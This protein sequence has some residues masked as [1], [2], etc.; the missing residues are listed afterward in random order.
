MSRRHLALTGLT[1]AAVAVAGAS[2]HPVVAQTPPPTIVSTYPCVSAAVGHDLTGTGWTPGGKV[3]IRGRYVIGKETG[4]AFDEM[5]TADEEGRIRFTYGVPDGEALTVGT[6]VT[7]QDLARTAA[8]APVEQ[9]SARTEYQATYYGVFYRPWNKR[10]A[11]GRPGHVGTIEASG[12]IG[13]AAR[14]TGVVYAHYYR[15]GDERWRS[16]R[17]GRLRGDCG[18]LKVRFREFP[19]KRPKP[20]SYTLRFDTMPFGSALTWDSVG[21]L[22]VR[23]G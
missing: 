1:L 3:R 17:V 22:R 13:R 5:V 14:L 20:G 12:W 7:A 21:Y 18:A 11:K 10:G 15:A 23:V 16:F 6:E 19:W 8:G 9:R 4:E 2:A